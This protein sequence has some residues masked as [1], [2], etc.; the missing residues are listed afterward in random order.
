MFKEIGSIGEGTR[1]PLFCKLLPIKRAGRYLLPPEVRTN[2]REGE[3]LHSNLIDG[4]LIP[5]LYSDDWISAVFGHS[6]SPLSMYKSEAF[7]EN[8][9][10]YMKTYHLDEWLPVVRRKIPQEE[11]IPLYERG[12][13]SDSFVSLYDVEPSEKKRIF[14]HGRFNGPLH[15]AIIETVLRIKKEFPDHEFY[16]GL[17][18][19]KSS[20]DKDQKSFMD[21]QFRATLLHRTG[22]FDKIVLLEPPLNWDDVYAMGGKIS[23]DVIVMSENEEIEEQRLQEISTRTKIRVAERI[24]R[25]IRGMHQT[26]IKSG[27]T[28]VEEV[29][30]GWE[31]VRRLLGDPGET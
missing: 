14:M 6:L 30:R 3:P 27:A 13:K 9:R 22:L 28:S 11:I 20:I 12:F 4:R 1:T 2:L 19:D 29:S 25:E 23:P 31:V 24:P 17:D 10:Q 15:P 5:Y 7:K 18:H 16:V 8:M 21:V 26:T